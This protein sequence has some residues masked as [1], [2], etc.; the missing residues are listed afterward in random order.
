MA[1][2]F[3]I[4]F[5]E[6]YIWDLVLRLANSF[7]NHVIQI[8]I[9]QMYFFITNFPNSEKLNSYVETITPYNQILYL[10]S[11]NSYVCPI[12]IFIFD[13]VKAKIKSAS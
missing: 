7:W 10:F 13:T 12:G 5:S 9:R 2:E 3:V 4:S 8:S 6:V 11:R 1:L